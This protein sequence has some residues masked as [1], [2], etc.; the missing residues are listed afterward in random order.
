MNGNNESNGLYTLF[1]GVGAF[2]SYA[3]LGGS[4]WY[5][6][7][8]FSTK[9]YWAMGIILLTISLVNVVKYRL[10]DR[11]SGD[12]INKL[13]AAKT[14]KILEDYVTTDN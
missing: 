11:A 12:R 14:E 4:L 8:D 2:I 6:P 9:G 5:A 10:D 1:N 3:M 13:E 7:V